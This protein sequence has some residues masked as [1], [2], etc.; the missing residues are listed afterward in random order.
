MN[1]LTKAGVLLT[2]VS[3]VPVVQMVRETVFLERGER[4]YRE[5]SQRELPIAFAGRTVQIIDSLPRRPYSE[6]EE[7]GLVTIAVDAVPV[8][9]PRHAMIRPG[10]SDLGRYHRWIN[11]AVFQDRRTGT[12]T[13]WIGRRIGAEG[14][15]PEA[16]E[17]LTLGDGG[18][19]SVRQV[20]HRARAS[21][22]RLFRIIHGMGGSSPSAYP[23]SLLNVW[24]SLFVP[25]LYPWA[26]FAVG[27]VLLVSGGVKRARM[28]GR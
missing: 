22:Y 2:V 20:P 7:P 23:W 12:A 6:A 11:A 14:P 4:R 18:A 24:P 16:Y 10:R 13:L 5:L 1:G 26:A 21:E 15:E 28:R 27:V 3:I 17:I 8:A 9:Q 25:F 19:M